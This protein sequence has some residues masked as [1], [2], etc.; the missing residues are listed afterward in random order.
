VLQ[1]VAGNV[2]HEVESGH[3]G[4]GSDVLRDE[5]EEVVG[6][7]ESRRDLQDRVNFVIGQLLQADSD[8]ID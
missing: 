2:V 3:L 4:V 6:E 8:D 7:I 1:L 5:V